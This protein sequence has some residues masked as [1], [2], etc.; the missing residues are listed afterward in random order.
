VHEIRVAPGKIIDG[1]DL[2]HLR[3]LTLTPLGKAG[4]DETTSVR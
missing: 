1:Q 3:T 4:T 2:M